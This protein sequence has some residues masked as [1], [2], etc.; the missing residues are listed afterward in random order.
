MIKYD[1]RKNNVFDSFAAESVML[2]L[3]IIG[4]LVILQ[5]DPKLEKNKIPFQKQN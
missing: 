5:S 3:N 4:G 1:N 2:S